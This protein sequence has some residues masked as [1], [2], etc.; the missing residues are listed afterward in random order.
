MPSDFAQTMSQEPAP[1]SIFITSP[2]PSSSATSHPSSSPAHDMLHHPSSPN[3]NLLMQRSS[4]LTVQTHNLSPH[5]A[6][7]GHSHHSPISP[8]A[9]TPFSTT[10]TSPSPMLSDDECSLYSPHSPHT[11]ITQSHSHS[12]QG[13]RLSSS[14]DPSTP[15]SS[16]TGAAD[17]SISVP[18]FPFVNHPL[19]PLSHQ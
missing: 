4:P 11:P 7:A 6:L 19:D 2:D 3:H 14:L 13:Q 5:E 15:S 9:L 16:S 1:P 10:S 18:P 12:H 8:L 17:H